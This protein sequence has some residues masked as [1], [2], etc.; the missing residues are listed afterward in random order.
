[1]ISCVFSHGECDLCQCL[2]KAIAS[3]PSCPAQKRFRHAPH[4]QAAL[5]CAPGLFVWTLRRTSGGM[6]RA[7]CCRIQ[8]PWAARSGRLPH[9]LGATKASS[10]WYHPHRPATRTMMARR[11]RAALAMLKDE[12]SIS[13]NSNRRRPRWRGSCSRARSTTSCKPLRRSDRVGLYV[14]LVR[15]MSD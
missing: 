12:A 15:L 13:T 7:T 3:V 2:D 9:P 1:M 5:P 8:W 10:R 14:K 4:N 6:R 11:R